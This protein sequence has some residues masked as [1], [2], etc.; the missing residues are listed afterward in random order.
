MRP[1]RPVRASPE[2]DRGGAVRFSALP[3]RVLILTASVGEG[4]DLPARTLAAQLRAERPEVEVV[5]E[6][7]LAA[8]GRFFVGVNERAPRV[9]FYRQQWVYDLA[10]WLFARVPPTRRAAQL[11]LTF[12]G[13]PGLLRLVRSVKPDVI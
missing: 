5:T 2:L 6:D 4:H 8:M 12:I 13:A 3:F 11:L 9:I 1:E 10:F 7:G